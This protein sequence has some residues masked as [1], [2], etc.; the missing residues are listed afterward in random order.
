VIRSFCFTV[1]GFAAALVLVSNAVWA[2]TPPPVVQGAGIAPA[3]PPPAGAPA[4]TGAATAIAGVTPELVDKPSFDDQGR[5][6]GWIARVSTAGTFSFANNSSVVGQQDGSS[7]SF[8]LKF[9][10]TLNFNREKHEWRNSLG[11]LGAMTRTPVID[12]FVKTSDSFTFDSTYLYHAVKIFGPFVRVSYNTSMFR[13]TDVRATQTHYFVQPVGSTMQPAGAMILPQCPVGSAPTVACEVTSGNANTGGRF[14][15]SDPFKP[16]TFKES[17]GVFLQPYASEPFSV[18]FRGG[19]GAQEV[20][21]ND[22][23][24]LQASPVAMPTVHFDAF[25]VDVKAL[26]DVNQLGAELAASV[27]GAFVTKKLTYKANFDAMTPFAHT[28]L[29]MGDTRSSFDLTNIHVDGA[30]SLHI[31]DWA[32]LDYNLKAIRQPQVVDAFQVQ[33]TLLLTFGQ[34]FTNAPPPPPPAPAPTV[35]VVPANQASPTILVVP[36]AR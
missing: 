31:V 27:W 33:N 11:I 3:P 7:I 14:A 26:A 5:V 10:G 35:V 2:Q 19:A 20:L 12:T 17:V 28:A 8:G 23:Y 9:D 34:T 22:Q 15:L 32:S 25:R 36:P 18:E 13:G 21:A 30:I 6:Q 16:S 29:P 4:P 1:P 24:A